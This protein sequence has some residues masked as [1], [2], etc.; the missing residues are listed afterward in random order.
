MNHFTTGCFENSHQHTSA[1]AERLKKSMQ[2]HT[3]R[4][5]SADDRNRLLQICCNTDHCRSPFLPTASPSA[6]PLKKLG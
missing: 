1:F 3:V 2:V 5:K 6:M 4:G